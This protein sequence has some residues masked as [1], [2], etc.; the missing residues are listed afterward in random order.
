MG[1]AP[2]GKFVGHRRVGIFGGTFDPPH[3]GHV[4]VAC[5][6]TDALDLHELLWVPAGE[7]PHKSGMGMTPASL[8]LRMTEVAAAVDPRFRV[9]DLETRRAG[10]SYMVD[11]LR[12]LRI[13]SVDA[14][15]F[16]LLGVDQY[17]ELDSWQDPDVIPTLARL[18]VLDRG[19]ESLPAGIS[20]GD[21]LSVP[22]AR[23]DISSTQVRAR[24]RDGRDVSDLVPAA[25]ARIIEAEGLYRG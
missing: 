7:P 8:R 9:C 4:A 25:V 18:A 15:L 14:D 3:N 21:V 13:A 1:R 19:G 22:V 16:L 24:V 5:E 2:D 6:A 17:L 23:I 20:Q 11:T 12:E 10:P